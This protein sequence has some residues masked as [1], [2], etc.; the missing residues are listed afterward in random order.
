MGLGAQAEVVTWP[1]DSCRHRSFCITS[2]GKR[3]NPPCGP[4][5]GWVGSR[6]ARLGVRVSPPPAIPSRAPALDKVVWPAVEVEKVRKKRVMRLTSGARASKKEKKEEGAAR[7][8][9]RS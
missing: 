9:L 5:H 7:A 2:R 8:G 6:A 3:G 4:A 1:A